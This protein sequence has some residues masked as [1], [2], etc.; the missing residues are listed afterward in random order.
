MLRVP[1]VEDA[2]EVFVVVVADAVVVD[3]VDAGFVATVLAE[4]LINALFFIRSF[5]LPCGDSGLLVTA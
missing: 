4:F 5:S 3:A 1:F 2:D